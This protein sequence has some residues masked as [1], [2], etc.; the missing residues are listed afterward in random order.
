MPEFLLIKFLRRGNKWSEILP[1]EGLGPS[2]RHL[3]KIP[4]TPAFNYVK[5]HMYPDGGIVSPSS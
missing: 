4:V 5:I 2:A 1:K 3:F